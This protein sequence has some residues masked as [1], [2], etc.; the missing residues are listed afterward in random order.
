MVPGLFWRSKRLKM[1]FRCLPSR[2]A[3]FRFCANLYVEPWDDHAV[4]SLMMEV[5]FE[6][7]RGDTMVPHKSSSSS[8]GEVCKCVSLVA[9]EPE[10][11]E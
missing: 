5:L 6:V 3:S 2:C 1:L 10:S 11:E 8:R 7:Q 4:T 9:R